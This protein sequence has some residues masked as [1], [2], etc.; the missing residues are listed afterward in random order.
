MKRLVIVVA[1]LLTGCATSTAAERVTAYCR[2]SPPSEG[3]LRIAV[4][5]TVYNVQF[6]PRTLY[7]QRCFNAAVELSQGH[8][9]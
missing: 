4:G 8:K 9:P 2:P 6:P 5:D 1:L 7:E 3:N